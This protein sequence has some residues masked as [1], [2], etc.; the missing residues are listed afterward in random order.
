MFKKGWQPENYKGVHDEIKQQ[1]MKTKDM[2]AKGRFEYFWYYYKVHTL[3]AVCV[4][5][6]G[7]SLIHDILTAKDYG[8]YGVMLNASLLD[9]EAMEASFGEY[10]QLDLNE[11][12]C[13]ID[14]QSQLSYHS[15]NSYDF[16]TY[17]KLVAQLQTHE[18]DVLV[19]DAEVFRNFATNEMFMDL[20]EFMSPEELAKYEDRIYY[21]DMEA[22]RKAA[23]AA[24][25]VLNEEESTADDA[26]PQDASGT[27]EAE[28]LSPDEA[29][30]AINPFG[31]NIDY[32]EIY[33]LAAEEAETHRHPEEMAEPVPV[34]IFLDESPFTEKTGSYGKMVPVYAVVVTSEKADTAV[35]YLNYLWDDTVPFDRMLNVF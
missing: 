21:V 13:M 6:F 5:I 9:S 20:R 11:Y 10:A 28:E 3:V 2:S 33:R 35:K 15:Q 1:H 32:D 12:D 16:A 17:Q 25:N 34:G 30:A 27:Q 22:V 26:A 14:T 19:A 23:E 29:E 7:G 31:R 4:I 18:L 24:D 8:F